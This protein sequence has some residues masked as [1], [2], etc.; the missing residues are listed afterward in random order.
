MPQLSNEPEPQSPVPTA[1]SSHLAEL[2]IVFLRLGTLAFGG[3][4]AHVAMMDQELV[5][6]RSWLSREQLLQQFSLTQL[7]PGPNSTELAMQIGYD[8][9]GFKGLI[10]AGVAFIVP[11]MIL[12][13]LLA[14]GYMQTQSL[15]Q[16]AQI[17][18]GVKPVIVAIVLQAIWK[19]GQK[20]LT[21]WTLLGA[22][23]LAVLGY[24]L[25]WNETGILVAIGLGILGLKMK[26]SQLLAW[27]SIPNLLLPTIPAE[28]HSGVASNAL[29]PWTQV[30]G[31]FFKIGL[32]LYGS[33]YV[34]LAFLQRELVD[35]THW[36]TAQ[37]LLDA[38]AIGQL[39]PGP[40]LTTATFVGYLL[41]GH[42]GAIAATV[43]IFLPGFLL[44]ALLNRWLM[45]WVQ[46]SEFQ[47]VLLG[48]NAASLGLMIGVTVNL[49]R[50]AWV[51]GWT[52]ALSIVSLGVLLR[53]KLNSAWLIA[54]G[55]AIGWGLKQVG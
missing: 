48:V 2:A 10:V 16:V 45:P 28:S 3:P 24:G 8:R 50:T 5:E 22:T 34:L 25:G 13:W 14:I 12:V 15:P 53:F 36:L 46:R 43:G 18:Y 31:I 29:I 20:T 27:V 33:G 19:F 39:T 6:R 38:I 32:V 54:I 49:A 44:V 42:G 11:A 21:D 9:A 52:I 47:T 55:A 30:F 4:V 35:R 51:D 23:A 1:P 26:R 40:V 37:Q 7:I 17:L 41:A